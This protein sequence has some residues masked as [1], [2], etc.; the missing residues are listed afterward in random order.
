MGESGVKRTRKKHNNTMKIT[1]KEK[2]KNLKGVKK[3]LAV[4]EEK[5]NSDSLPFLYETLASV[6]REGKSNAIETKHIQSI[7]GIKD[8]R[9]VREIIEQLINKYGYCI[10]SSRQGKKKGYYLI[11]DKSELEETLRSY[12]AQIMSMLKRH[13]SLQ[14]N[15]ADKD[16]LELEV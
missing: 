10:G 11:T 4:V 13:R 5:K 16:Q 7:T 14:K 1:G 3:L 8:V 9:Q 12:N 15:F 6:L 2:L